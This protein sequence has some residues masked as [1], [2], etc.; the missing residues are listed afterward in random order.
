MGSISGTSGKAE[1]FGDQQCI[2]QAR[3]VVIVSMKLTKPERNLF[4]CPGF[5]VITNVNFLTM[6]SRS[7]LSDEILWNSYRV[8]RSICVAINS[9]PCIIN[10]IIIMI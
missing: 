3:V 5:A 6:S 10:Q 4:Q 9:T 8:A 7:L 1:A 2:P